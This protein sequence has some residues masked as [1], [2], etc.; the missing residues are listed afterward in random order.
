MK[1]WKQRHLINGIEPNGWF[2]YCQIGERIMKSWWSS[3]NK[4]YCGDMQYLMD[5]GYG[6]VNTDKR[7]DKFRELW[8]VLWEDK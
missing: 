5:R 7:V 3:P 2:V 1:L 8:N 6:K 4:H